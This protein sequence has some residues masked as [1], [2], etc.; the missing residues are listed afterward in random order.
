M[1]SDLPEQLS[2]AHIALGASA[3][4]GLFLL[5]RY[6]TSRP[7]LPYPPGPRPFPI[8]GS[9]CIALSSPRP[10]ILTRSDSATHRPARY[11]NVKIRA[12]VGQVWREVR[13]LNVPEGS[14]STFP[15]FELARGCQGTLGHSRVYV[16]RPTE[17]RYGYGIGR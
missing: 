6:L 2:T 15:H 14:G 1:L 7:S 5:R 12:R 11:A 13:S 8:I 4:L 16:R 17:V 10:L 9:E 3:G